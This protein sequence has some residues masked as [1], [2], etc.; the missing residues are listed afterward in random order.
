MFPVSLQ[1]SF[2]DYTNDKMSEPLLTLGA[3]QLA[4]LIRDR[5]VS[6][7]E[8][9]ETHLQRIDQVNGHLNAVIQLDVES[10]LRSAVDADDVLSRGG[11]PG[12]FHGVPFTVKDWIEASGLICA[13]GMQECR[14]FIPQRDATVVA[15]MKSAG[16]ILLGKTNVVSGQPVYPRPNN[17]HDLNRTPGSSSSGEAAIVAAGGSPLGLASDSG[18]SIRV[19]AHFCGVVGYRPSTGLVPLTG[20]YPRIGPLSD[21]RTSIGPI[22]RRVEDLYAILRTICGPDGIDPSVVPVP[23]TDTGTVDLAALRVAWFTAIE[24]AYPTS[25]TVAAVESAARALRDRGACVQESRPPDIDRSLGI[26][27][28]YWA[29]VRSISWK[30]WTPG[31]KSKLSGDETERSI[32]EWERFQR[33]ILAFMRD[34]DVVITPAAAGPAFSHREMVGD[35]YVYALPWSLTGQPAIVLPCSIDSEN[36]PIGVQVVSRRWRDDVAI[37]VAKVLEESFGG[38]RIARVAF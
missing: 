13:A 26:T 20:H 24:G 15:R 7:R 29:R 28:S 11:K 31:E 17:P 32:F 16:A 27:Q 4:R 38:W 30:G 9:V 2:S 10:A 25:R 6:S 37:G 8:V 19:P 14:T 12:P 3:V 36:M 5:E 22:T 23:V 34:F 21:P 33:A 35:D 18:G 1:R